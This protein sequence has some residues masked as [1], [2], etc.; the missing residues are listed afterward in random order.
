ME[1]KRKELCDKIY[2]M[3]R[4][5]KSFAQICKDLELKDYEV[6]GLITLMSEQGYNINFING[7]IIVLKN[8]PKNNLTNNLVGSFSLSF[9][10]INIPIRKTGNTEII[11]K[12]ISFILFK[13]K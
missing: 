9:L 12:S 8:P 10:Y 11:N 5:K 6:V 3:A 13:L 2:Y 4:K 7:E 1:K